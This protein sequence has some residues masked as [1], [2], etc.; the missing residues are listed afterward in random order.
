MSIF[1]HLRMDGFN[2][3]FSCISLFTYY[4]SWD[5]KALYFVKFIVFSNLQFFVFIQSFSMLELSK[6]LASQLNLRYSFYPFKLCSLKQ[7]HQLLLY[8]CFSYTY[9]MLDYLLIP[10]V[11]WFRISRFKTLLDLAMSSSPYG[12]RVLHIPMVLSQV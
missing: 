4:L 1:N 2:I 7:F 12:W 9:V 8:F 6:S 3:L 5:R 11:L 10:L